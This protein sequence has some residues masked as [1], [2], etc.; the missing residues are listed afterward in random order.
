MSNL[1]E[2]LWVLPA[3]AM[4][5]A[6]V[7]LAN[8]SVTITRNIASVPLAFTENQG[9]WHEQVSFRAN[10]GGATMWFTSDGAYYQFTRRVPSNSVIASDRGERGDLMGARDVTL[11][12]VEGRE[13][14][15]DRVTLS[16]VEGSGVEG[17]HHPPDSIETM[18]IKASFMGANTDAPIEGIHAM[19][20]KCNYFLGNDPEKWHTDVPNYEAIIYEDIYPG[21]D[22][23]YYGNGKQMEYD[24]IVSP[25]A[26]PSQIAVQYNGATSINV[27]ESGEL[28]VETD[29]G[30][31]V[32]HKP[33][34]YQMVDNS[35]ELFEC[36]FALN[37]DNVFS[38]YL[39][40]GYD[41]ELALVIDPVLVYST[42]LGGSTKDIGFG[43][44]LDGSGNTYITGITHSTDFPTL[45]PYQGTNQSYGDVFV[46]KLS[47]SG[48]SLIYS[49]YLGGEGADSARGIAVDGSGNAYITGMTRSTDFPTKEA[50]QIE[51]GGFYTDGFVTKLN[52]SGN[53]LVYSTYLGGNYYDEGNDISVDGSGNAYITGVTRS[54]NF[55]TEGAY[56]ATFNGGERDAFVTK[57]NSSG[58]DL[59]YST[60]LGGN[61]SD[62]GMA[63]VVDG[64]G[65]AY[66]AG[67][68]TS[69]DFPIE[70][71]YQTDQA[72]DDVFVTKLNSSGNGLIYSTYLGGNDG[73]YCGDISVDGSGNAY[74]TGHTYST[75]FPTEGAYQ[76]TK[77]GNGDIFV[78]KLNSSGNDL[79]YSTYLGGVSS[80]RSWGISV[81]GF[82]NAYITGSTYS[83]DFPTESEYQTDQDDRDVIVTKLNSSGNA[84]IYS[85]YLGGSGDEQARG[86]AVDGFG[87]AYIT[88]WTTS[89]DFPTQG[90]YQTFQGSTDAFVTKL[91]QSCCIPPIRGNV[92]YDPSDEIDISDLVYLVD[93]MFN[94]GPA[95]LCWPEANVDCSGPATPPD[96]GADDIDISDL[97]HLVDYMFNGGPEPVACP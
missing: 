74:I 28:V 13:I 34:V 60:Y 63:I 8:E 56:Q 41:L 39:P 93:Y 78:T 88:G 5:C 79:V 86:I 67:N 30:K 17:R 1:S 6:S 69:S 80:D 73:D 62:R 26:D 90:E 35:R 16:A 37:D 21:I 22:L 75:D 57:L 55:P 27:N 89:S 3:V 91:Y 32:E 81:D 82:G 40:R 47:S 54:T 36:E 50:Y 7:V 72:W 96:E 95:P 92:D 48:N 4:L 64:F 77:A 10:A 29:W 24:F 59:V 85:T 2:T 70:G 33:Y 84:L 25:G 51:H 45:N 46:T 65:N 38:F 71:E 87:N 58:N 83:I 20:Y 61:Y 9:Q 44:A 42:Y 97:V 68:T 12:G 76:T 23:K 19:E 66:I 43:I 94:Q 15:L 52:S 11:S 49:T 31:V 18:M 53:D 14:R